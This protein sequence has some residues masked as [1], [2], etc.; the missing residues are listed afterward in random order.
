MPMALLVGID[1]SKLTRYSLPFSYSYT[2]PTDA[3]VA[4]YSCMKSL[5]YSQ[6][7]PVSRANIILKFFNYTN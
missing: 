4:I 1:A 7:I 3:R 5:G 2:Y 6:M